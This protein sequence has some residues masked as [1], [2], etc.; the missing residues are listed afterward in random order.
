VR[1]HDS[2]IQKAIFDL[3]RIDSE[4]AERRFGFLLDALRFGAPPHA[5][6]AL[7][8]DRWVMMLAG[9]DNIREV[10]AFPKTQRAADL[11]SGA[12]SEVDEQQ[13]LDL[14]I[15]LSEPPAAE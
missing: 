9:N 5:G 2:E 8:L 7:G 1:I 14:H 15:E 11:L 12:P 4:E 6:I 10:I 3:L 13:L